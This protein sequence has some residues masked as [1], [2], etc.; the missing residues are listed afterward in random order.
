ML[1]PHEPTFVAL[2]SLGVALNPHDEP[3]VVLKRLSGAFSGDP[4]VARR[5]GVHFKAL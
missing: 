3:F 4:I 1:T 5:R 2:N